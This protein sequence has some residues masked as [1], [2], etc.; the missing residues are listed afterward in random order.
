MADNGSTTRAVQEIIDHEDVLE[1][2]VSAAHETIRRYHHKCLQI[3]QT[4]ARSGRLPHKEKNEAILA[5][6]ASLLAMGTP[7]I[8]DMDDVPF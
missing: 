6:I 3:A 7:E 1:S 4:L 2:R 8:R 5:A